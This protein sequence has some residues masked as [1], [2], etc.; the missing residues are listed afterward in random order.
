MMVRNAIDLYKNNSQ[1]LFIKVCQLK[2]HRGV[3][4]NLIFSVIFCSLF[5]DAVAGKKCS[6]AVIFVRSKGPCSVA[7]DCR[8]QSLDQIFI[9]S[10]F[11]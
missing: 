1:S 5:D 2:K 9:L 4:E 6:T 8:D 10:Q 11:Q 7:N 3:I